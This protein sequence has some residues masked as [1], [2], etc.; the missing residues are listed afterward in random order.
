MNINTNNWLNNMLL[1]SIVIPVL[2][3]FLNTSTS[4][5]KIHH[6]KYQISNSKILDAI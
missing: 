2:N 3:N 6:S 4:Y 5:K 1:G